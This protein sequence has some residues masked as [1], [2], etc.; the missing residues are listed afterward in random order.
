MGDKSIKKREIKKK[1][2]DKKTGVPAAS[3]ASVVT[4]PSA[5]SVP[6]VVKP[7]KVK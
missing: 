2:A 3:I 1:K 7:N 5:A 4:T 6:T